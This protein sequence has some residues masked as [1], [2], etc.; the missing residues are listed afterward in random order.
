MTVRISAMKS[1]L[2]ILSMAV[3]TCPGLCRLFYL[4]TLSFWW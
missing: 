1:L 2:F 4:F 3:W